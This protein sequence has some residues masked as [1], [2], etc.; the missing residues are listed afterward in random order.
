M[1]AASTRTRSIAALLVV[2]AAPMVWF[3][4][5]VVMYGAEAL[6]CM[7]GAVATRHGGFVVFAGAITTIALAI[8]AGIA[9]LRFIGDRRRG[10]RSAPDTWIFLRDVAAMLAFLAGVGVLWLALPA[11]V[12]TLCTSA[13]A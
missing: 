2:F 3:S 9:L 8:I 10:S 5:F 1:I 6:I 4:H 13:V 7:D 11:T 12:L